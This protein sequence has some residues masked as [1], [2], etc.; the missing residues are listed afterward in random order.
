MYAKASSAPF[1]GG[2]A[3]LSHP[4]TPI[5]GHTYKITYTVGNYGGD[6]VLEVELGGQTGTQRTGNGTY[7]DILT[8][9]TTTTLLFR[10][11]GNAPSAVS[12]S[13]DNVSIY[14]IGYRARYPSGARMR[15]RYS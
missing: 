4:F 9:T 11:T 8:A 15:G 12:L 2:G 5:I 7:S 1:A 3:R 10:A 14:S 6:G 13:I